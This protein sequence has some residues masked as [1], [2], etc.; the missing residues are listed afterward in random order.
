MPSLSKRSTVLINL[1]GRCCANLLLAL[2]ILV[3]R[4]DG[5]EAL[6]PHNNAHFNKEE[7]MWEDLFTKHSL[8]EVK[9]S[10]PVV[11]KPGLRELAEAE[12]ALGD[13]L[14][15]SYRAFCMEIGPCIILDFIRIY[16]PCADNDSADL[17]KNAMDWKQYSDK[18]MEKYSWPAGVPKY[19]FPVN[20]LIVFADTMEGDNFGFYTKEKTAGDEYP[21][22]MISS[23]EMKVYKVAD[24]F[25]DF[26]ENVVFGKRLVELGIFSDLGEMKK[27]WEP[28]IQYRKKTPANK[29]KT[30]AK[31]K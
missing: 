25:P 14:P 18:D 30:P 10:K 26:I 2:F 8:K 5:V 22:Y 1:K 12:A 21:I 15:P 29:K 31:K 20:E 6:G 23:E 11:G 24:S 16:A 13:P 19:S 9:P 17:V 27:T 28:F 7:V 4:Q 3:W